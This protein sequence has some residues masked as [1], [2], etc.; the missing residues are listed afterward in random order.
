MRAHVRLE[1]ISL[2][3]DLRQLDFDL[4]L[5]ETATAKHRTNFSR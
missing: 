5:V 2:D 4:E 1:I 3:P